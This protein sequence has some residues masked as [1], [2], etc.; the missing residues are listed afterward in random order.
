MSENDSVV[1]IVWW[2]NCGLILKDVFVM[3]FV[4]VLSRL[5]FFFFQGNKVCDECLWIIQTVTSFSAPLF[6]S[7]F[8]SADC[9]GDFLV[10]SLI[11][12]IRFNLFL[13]YWSRETAVCVLN[14]MSLNFLL[15]VNLL[16][17]VRKNGELVV[18]T[19][20]FL[21]SNFMNFLS[22]YSWLVELPVTVALSVT[23]LNILDSFIC[24][25]FSRE[26]N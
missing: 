10:C 14:F 23:V 19:V 16:S 7:L 20:G 6:Y 2:R 21:G 26:C 1:E 24:F 25:S 12:R 4:K 13:S 5:R 9:F 11:F 3:S 18:C 15:L 8:Y 22:V 17:F